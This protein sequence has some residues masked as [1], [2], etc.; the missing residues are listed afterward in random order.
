MADDMLVSILIKALNEEQKIAA[1]L[2]ATVR[3]ASK[4]GGEVILADSISSDRTVEIAGKFPVQVVQFENIDDRGCGAATQLGYQYARGEFLYLIDGDMV[5]LPDFLSVA[6]EYLQKNPS[7]G[8]VGGLIID[9][10][11]NTP[12]DKRRTNQYA[13]I[14]K[15]ILVDHLGGGGLYRASAI[16]S[17]SY[18]ANRWLKACEEADLGFRL[19]CA[20]WNLIR[21]PIPAVTHTGHSESGLDMLRRIWRNR[22]MHAHGVFLRSALGQPWCWATI[23]H[24]WFVYAAP[25][26]YL[27]ALPLS[28]LM[29][30]VGVKIVAALFLSTVFSWILVFI[31]LCA[32]KRSFTQA[33]LSIVAWHL[34]TFAAA[35]GMLNKV[36]NPR[37]IIKSRVISDKS[38]VNFF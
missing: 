4:F 27:A 37:E 11:E 3:E 17:I 35:V 26:I 36:N 22:R 13:T 5:L 19:K 25:V 32:R 38:R 2:Q 8:G 31:I 23:R 34:Y 30:H 21:L 12:D 29:F 1:C 15:A 9:M 28:L 16:R 24:V 10:Q 7:V 33:A 18:I 6:I 20:G 14:K